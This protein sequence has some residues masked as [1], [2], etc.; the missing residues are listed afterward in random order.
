MAVTFNTNSIL[1]K[2]RRGETFQVVV[3]Y[4]SD[5]T[6]VEAPQIYYAGDQ[7]DWITVTNT[8]ITEQDYTYEIVVSEYTSS[9][10]SPRTANIVFRATTSA[11]S[12]SSV[13]SIYQIHS[14]NSLWKDE[15]M[16]MTR[17]SNMSYILTDESDKQLYKGVAAITTSATGYNHI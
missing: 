11:G 6:S 15:V 14:Y 7:N 1:Y 9:L 3:K 17:T 12:E 16:T 8:L 5:T 13:L 4:P 10:S 2:P